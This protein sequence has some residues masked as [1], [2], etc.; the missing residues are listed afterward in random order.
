MKISESDVA[1][2]RDRPTEGS[3][4]V[5]IETLSREA[6]PALFTPSWTFFPS[7]LGDTFGFG[8]VVAIL[9]FTKL[10]PK[11]AP[12]LDWFAIKH[13]S[14]GYACSHPRFVGV[15]LALRPTITAHL[16][17]LANDYRGHK[18]GYFSLTDK[19]TTDI[20]VYN[21]RL[22]LIGLNC[23]FTYPWLH[24]G[25]YPIDATPEALSR[26]TNTPPDL[27]QFGDSWAPRPPDFGVFVL[28]TNCD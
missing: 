1:A 10:L 8:G 3:R 25:V 19:S 18:N 11:L 21:A 15:R 22:K 23:E 17:V 14:G 7:E 5:R 12:E 20:E 28:A 16:E 4:Y 27:E 2:F 13:Q 6:S 26:L 24:E 9:G